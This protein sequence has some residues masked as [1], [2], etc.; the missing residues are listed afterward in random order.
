MKLL[1]NT[2]PSFIILACLLILAFFL[3]DMAGSLGLIGSI[4][5]V[6]FAVVVYNSWSNSAKN[7]QPPPDDKIDER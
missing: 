7:S 6:A 5:I 3:P 2:V 1:P 4:A